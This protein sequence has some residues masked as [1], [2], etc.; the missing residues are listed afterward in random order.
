[1][2]ICAIVAAFNE[3]RT[4]AEV[5]TGVRQHVPDVVVVDDGST[6]RT[7]DRAAAAGATVLVHSRNQGKGTAIRT[8]L[9]H[10]LPQPHSHVLFIDGDLQHDPADI[11]RLMAAAEGSKA[12]FVIAE[13]AFTRGQMPTARFYSNRIG[14]RILS[15]FIGTDV[16][17]SQSGFRLVRSD[18]LRGRA[19][20]GDGLRTRNR[21]AHQADEARCLPPP[22]QHRGPLRRREQ[23][24][25]F[26]QGHLPHM[27]AGRV[28]SLPRRPM[29]VP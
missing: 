10:V 1:M 27:Y 28:V 26:V 11:P 9:A 21:D 23:Q 16:A 22:R 5:V 17:D 3:E 20:D 14:S 18:S 29:I 15:G 19:A 12:D 6:D 24:T 7:A 13:R 8:G 2:T 25:A 4:I